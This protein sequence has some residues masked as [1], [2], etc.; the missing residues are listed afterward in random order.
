MNRTKLT[1]I[2]LSEALIVVFIAG[3]VLLEVNL[4][5]N[6]ARTG[7]VKTALVRVWGSRGQGS[8]QLDAPRGIAVWGG[9]VYVADMAN[10]RVQ[11]FTATGTPVARWGGRGEG[12]GPEPVEGDGHLFEPSDVAV[13][14]HGFVYVIDPW[15]AVVQK[16]TADG[17]FVA[18]YGGPEYQFFRPQ[19]VAV[20]RVGNI[21]VTDTGGGRVLVFDYGGRLLAKWGRIGTEPGEMKEPLGIAVDDQGFVYVAD[22]GNGRIQVFDSSGRFVDQWPVHGHPRYLAIDNQRRVYVTDSMNN[23]VWVFHASGGLAG[24]VSGRDDRSLFD[25]PQGIAVGDDRMLYVVN[26]IRVSVY[27]AI[28]Q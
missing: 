4:L 26:S 13:D 23:T 20:D 14:A 10:S 12:L 1:L 2:Y 25:G 19:G 27:E 6:I 21:Y 28:N 15:T 3:I 7:E 5:A 24:K 11:K 17:E 22:T 9:F 18:R 8:A 16:F